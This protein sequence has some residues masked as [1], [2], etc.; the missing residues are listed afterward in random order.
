MAQ[1]ETS[2]VFLFLAM[3]TSLLWVER[4]KRKG[5]NTSLV[6]AGFLV[7]MFE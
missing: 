4:Q 2:Q 5:T 7:G 3:E 1:S 6:L